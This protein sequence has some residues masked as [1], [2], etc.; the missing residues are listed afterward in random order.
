[1]AIAHGDIRAKRT[2]EARDACV[3]TEATT[4]YRKR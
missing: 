1:M 2:D 3:T 4:A